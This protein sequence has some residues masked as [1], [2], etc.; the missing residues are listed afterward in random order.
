MDAQCKEYISTGNKDKLIQ[1]IYQCEDINKL[2]SEKTYCFPLT[3]ACKTSNYDIV[4]LCL[5]AGADPMFQH[6]TRGYYFEIFDAITPDTRRIFE[7]FIERDIPIHTAIPHVIWKIFTVATATGSEI[8]YKY[9]RAHGYSITNTSIDGINPFMIS[10]S[11]SMRMIPKDTIVTNATWLC[12]VGLVDNKLFQKFKHRIKDCTESDYHT[13]LN[14]L[15]LPYLFRN[16]EKV[17]HIL[18]RLFARTEIAKH[19]DSWLARDDIPRQ[20]L[21]FE[22]CLLINYKRCRPMLFASDISSD[23]FTAEK[24]AKMSKD[25][26]EGFIKVQYT[27]ITLNDIILSDKYVSKLC[28]LFECSDNISMIVPNLFNIIMFTKSYNNR[29]LSILVKSKLSWNIP[30]PPGKPRVITW[31]VEN[32]C[33]IT[34]P[35]LIAYEFSFDWKYD[36]E[37]SVFSYIMKSTNTCTPELTL[38]LSETTYNVFEHEIDGRKLID[39]FKD[40]SDNLTKQIVK[41]E[42]SD[43]QL[44]VLFAKKFCKT[45]HQLV[46]KKCISMD[47]LV[48]KL[49]KYDLVEYLDYS[50]P[51]IVFPIYVLIVN[52]SIKCSKCV[53]KPSTVEKLRDVGINIVHA[54]KFYCGNTSEMYNL[55]CSAFG[56][57]SLWRG[58]TKHDI[59]RFNIILTDLANISYCPFCLQISMR[60]AGCT[61]MKH[62]C[63][64]NA[65]K[66]VATWFK[67][68]VEWC[69]TCNSP[70]YDHKHLVKTVDFTVPPTLN[71]TKYNTPCDPTVGLDM[72]LT[73]MQR[74]LEK[75]HSLLPQIGKIS[76]DDAI[77]LLVVEALTSYTKPLPE[78]V[79]AKIKT[80]SK[81][82]IPIDDFPDSYADVKDMEYIKKYKRIHGKFEIIP[83][84]DAVDSVSMETCN[85]CYQFNH[86]STCHADE[87]VGIETLHN[88]IKI[89]NSRYGTDDFGKCWS[90]SELL[91]P[92][93]LYEVVK[94]HANPAETEAF[95][96]DIDIY[97]EYHLQR[98]GF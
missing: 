37:M 60:T 5:N 1:L 26:I 41:Y 61:Y 95:A 81:F 33:F 59:D 22:L 58:L 30:S 92:A 36:S 43:A 66:L 14:M 82:A 46:C 20:A 84:K 7:L 57:F 74:M 56:V 10:S 15:C 83:H 94:L 91:H 64:F 70:T 42:V 80:D 89:Q 29:L 35:R 79:L 78:D 32:E 55:V 48:N 19:I 24:F 49:A 52:N 21:E 34:L 85:I 73:S 87:L 12:N 2:S 23:A 71:T 77:E 50:E 9:L 98:F 72:K 3:Y 11:K 45:I 47:V 67:N 25:A 28:D 65:S 75:A 76:H 38:K 44:D 97:A 6:P 53:L 90:C 8:I 68:R 88:Y 17:E 96:K 13:C 39:Y 4:E 62:E 31:C 86:G 16:N 40:C 27:A 54:A 93:E 69:V 63:K 18:S 51:Q